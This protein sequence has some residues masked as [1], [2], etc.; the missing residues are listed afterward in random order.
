MKELGN[1]RIQGN[2]LRMRELREAGAKEEWERW[3]GKD[4]GSGYRKNRDPDPGTR[5]LC[6][7]SLFH[8][9]F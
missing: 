9:D 4:I 8:D 5:H 6:L 2:E 7:E 3:E 1:E